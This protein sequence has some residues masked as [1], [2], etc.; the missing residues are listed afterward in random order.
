[1][2]AAKVLCLELCYRYNIA[3]SFAKIM[4]KKKEFIRNPERNMKTEENNET[5]LL[6]DDEEM[7]LT[8][9]DSFLTLETQY[10]VVKFI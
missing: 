6:V 1:V 10:S 5:I 2:K 8:S 4:T 9:L 7:V 3:L